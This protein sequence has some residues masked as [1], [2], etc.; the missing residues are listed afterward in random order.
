[1]ESKERKKELKEHKTLALNPTTT[2]SGSSLLNVPHIGIVNSFYH[3]MNSY[4]KHIYKCTTGG[5]YQLY[6]RGVS[7][8]QEGRISWYSYVRVLCS[9]MK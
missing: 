7:A 1:M 5:A 6:R 9:A 8:L 3:P 4:S 2:Q